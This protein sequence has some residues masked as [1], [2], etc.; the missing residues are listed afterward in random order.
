MTLIEA[1]LHSRRFWLGILGAVLTVVTGAT[2]VLPHA[3]YGALYT[4]GAII[5][6]A[7]LGDSYVSGKTASAAKAGSTK[8]VTTVA[9]GAGGAG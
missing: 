2:G 9:T 3:D 8:A 1:E 7:I 6:S 5:V 4:A